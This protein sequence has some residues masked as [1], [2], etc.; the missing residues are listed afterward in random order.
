MEQ[1][2]KDTQWLADRGGLSANDLRELVGYPRKNDPF[3]DQYFVSSHLVPIE[4]AGIR[5]TE[6]TGVVARG[7]P[8]PPTPPPDPQKQPV[9]EKPKKDATP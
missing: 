8:L 4:I 1:V 3:L 7:A 9:L 2:G 5:A 6:P